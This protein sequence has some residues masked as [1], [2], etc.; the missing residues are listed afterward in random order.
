MGGVVSIDL[1]VD[2]MFEN[3]VG[4]VNTRGN[5]GDYLIVTTE[6]GDII[7]HPNAAFMPSDEEVINIESV[8]NGIYAK[9]MGS[10]DAFIDYN[11][12]ESYMTVGNSEVVGW[13]IYYISPS[14]YYDSMV[15]G[16]KTKMVLTSIICIVLACGAAVF[17]SFRLIKPITGLKK[18]L[19]NITD[20]IQKGE[21]DLTKRIEVK[22]KDELAELADGINTFIESLQNIIGKIKEASIELQNSREKIEEEINSSNDS[23]ANISAITEELAA[24][25]SLVSDSSTG[26]SSSTDAVLERTEALVGDVEEGNK[27]VKEME[28][29]ASAVRALVSEK[30]ESTTE[31]VSAKNEKLKEAIAESQKVDDIS[32]LADDILSIANQTNLL[33]LNASIEAARAG[34]QGKGFAV[35]A[36]EIRDLAENSQKTANTI[37]EI[38]QNV[39]DA[40]NNLR[41][42]SDELIEVMNKMLSE[43]YQK[44]DEVGSEYYKDAEYVLNLL[45]SFRENSQRVQESMD[46]ASSGVASITKN[47]A[48]CSKGITE[49]AES[50][51]SLVQLMSSIKSEND[52]N[53]N[54]VDELLTETSAFKEV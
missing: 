40:V 39:I 14:Q 21:G 8:A 19:N 44:F 36:I 38:S 4:L 12:V 34:E 29:R 37:Q 22:S 24:S 31:I 32:K 47:I 26:I 18:D 43:D 9:A 41:V 48:D 53:S 16:V 13:K 5:A 2:K 25:M 30:I 51:V 15:L 45:N 1:Y 50:T 3:L 49:V 28:E 54:N 23:A 33:A 20:T 35:V 42:T 7:Y 52:A 10:R 27:Y 46:S 17:L 6:G 11:G